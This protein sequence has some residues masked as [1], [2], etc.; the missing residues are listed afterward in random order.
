MSSKVIKINPN[1]IATNKD[2]LIGIIYGF[3]A[4]RKRL[5]Q[6]VKPLFNNKEATNKDFYLGSWLELTCFKC[7]HLYTFD[8]SNELPSETMKCI[9]EGCNNIIILYGITQPNM[10][11]IGE[12]TFV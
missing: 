7:G 8:N 11:R 12:I 6:N 3:N 5:E 10:W 4:A 9:Q 2:F 1:I